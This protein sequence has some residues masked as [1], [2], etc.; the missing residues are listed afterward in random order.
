MK[1]KVKYLSA[2]VMLVASIIYLLFVPLTF[3]PILTAFTIM[4]LLLSVI[5]LLLFSGKISLVKEKKTKRFFLQKNK[6]KK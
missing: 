5:L 2:T 6:S 4:N 3:I 1:N